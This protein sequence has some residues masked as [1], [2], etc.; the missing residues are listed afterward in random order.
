M[1]HRVCITYITF[2]YQYISHIQIRVMN[3]AENYTLYN[4]KVGF[5]GVYIFFSFLTHYRL[6]AFVDAVLMRTHNLCLKQTNGEKSDS[7]S[8]E[9]WYS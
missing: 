2:P 5:T 9:N 8:S 6:W 4:G 7:L 1:K 3:T